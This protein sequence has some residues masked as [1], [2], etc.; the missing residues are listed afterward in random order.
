M[1]QPQVMAAGDVY[2]GP[3]VPAALVELPG[4]TLCSVVELS[5]G[6][7]DLLRDRPG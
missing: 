7:H 6:R 2:D 3:E 4:R 5:T 1:K